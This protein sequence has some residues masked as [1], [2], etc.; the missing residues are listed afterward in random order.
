MR[1]IRWQE[2]GAWKRKFVW[3]LR[4]AIAFARNLHF[5]GKVERYDTVIVLGLGKV[6]F[7]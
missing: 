3:G 7:V 5:E 6:L 4:R 1:V 2:N